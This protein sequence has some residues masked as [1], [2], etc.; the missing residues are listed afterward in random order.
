[1]K[2]AYL[3]FAHKNPEQFIR[4]LKA[5]D[6]EESRFFIHIDKKVQIDGFK[7]IVQ[8]IDQS[9]ITWLKRYSIVW[10]GF[11]Q[12]R[13]TLEGLKAVAASNENI[14]YVSF[15]SSQDYPIKPVKGFHKYLYESQGK[16]FIEY[17][18]LPRRNWA[19]G[20]LDRIHYYH[21][22][23][24]SFRI[25]FPLISYL[26]VKLPFTTEPKWS[27]LKKII[28]FIPAAKK[29]PRK[30]LK[31][32]T[33]YEGSNWFTLHINLV[34]ETLDELEQNKNFYRYFKYTHHADEIFFQTIIINKCLKNSANIVNNNLRFVDWTENTGRPMIYRLQHFDMLKNNDCF[35]ARKFD[36]EADTA[37][38][39]KL[40][41]EILQ[42]EN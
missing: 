28:P 9:K 2:F 15:I 41:K 33:L 1:M 5:L 7:K 12:I 22:L 3:I 34:K 30:F 20:G 26:K 24:P 10:A 6:T 32:Y 25:A 39:D 19:N 38:L 14:D 18:K 27:V 4:L 8:Q 36:I 11:N 37:I 21:F 29:F 35:F 31:D 42:P 23:F 17:F 40:D 13:A 16:S